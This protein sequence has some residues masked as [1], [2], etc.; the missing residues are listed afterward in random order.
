MHSTKLL[1]KTWSS[2]IHD[3]SSCM[4]HDV[5]QKKQSHDCD[6]FSNCRCHVHV[7]SLWMFWVRKRLWFGKVRKNQGL[8]LSGIIQMKKN[9]F[10]N[11]SESKNM[12]HIFYFSIEFWVKCE[13]CILPHVAGLE[14]I[15]G[16]LRVGFPIS[17]EALPIWKLT[18]QPI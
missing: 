13:Y 5:T 17:T 6:A 2:F 3:N 14:T 1:Y 18:L 7:C 8:I 16:I 12:G 10:T 4:M 9:P 11:F 15:N